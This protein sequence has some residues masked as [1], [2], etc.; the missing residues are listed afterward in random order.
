VNQGIFVT[1]TDTGVGK[2]FVTAGI[3]RWLRIKGV[4]AV[5]MKPVQTGGEWQGNH[6]VAPD[7]EFCLSA[8]GPELSDDEMRLASPYIFEPACSPHLAGR[9]TGQYIDMSVIKD[10][11]RRLAGSHEVVVIEGSG[12]IMVPLN[13]SET[14]LDLMKTLGYPVVLV[15]RVGL[16]SIN[17]A[18]L[19]IEALRSAGIEV[20][21][22][23]FN[24]VEPPA[25]EDC[26][27]EQDNPDA[28][29]RFGRVKVLGNIPYLDTHESTEE[30][31][32]IFE[33]SM[34]GLHEIEQFVRATNG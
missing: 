23:V 22:I 6:L 24:R 20:I 7:L 13:E 32:A 3:V 8:G 34:P 16:G 27:I 19:S 31:W 2:T 25:T 1:G 11:S 33:R 12:G 5:P 17:H 26:F 18:L 14:M 28:I 15:S 21:G 4:E 30:T 29:A 9:M 10:Y